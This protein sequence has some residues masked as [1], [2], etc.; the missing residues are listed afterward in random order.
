MGG[1]SGGKV[2]VSEYSMSMHVGICA[3]GDT[4]ELLNIKVGEKIAWKGSL[5]NNDVLLIDRPELF[6]GNKKEGGLR[7]LLWWLPGDRSQTLPTPLCQRLGR[8][9]T[10]TPGFRG[11]ASVFFTGV[12]GNTM[13]AADVVRWPRFYGV[14]GSQAVPQPGSIWELIYTKLGGA[15]QGF[16]WCAN[17][18]YLKELSARVRRAPEGLNPS[19]AMI[20]IQNASDGTAQYAANPAH[21]IFECMVNRDWGMGE[22]YGAIDI[23]SYEACAQTL[24]DEKFGLNLLWTRQAKIEDFIREV[25]DHVQGAQFVDPGTGKHTMKL[26]RADYNFNALPIVTVDNAK[27]GNFKRKTWGEITNE[28]TVTWTNP[29]SGKEETVTVQDNAAI[30]MQGSTSTDSRN[31]HAIANRALAIRVAERDLAA[32]VHPI[33]TCE[34]EVSREFWQTVVYGVV[35]L[36]WEKYGIADVAFRV[37]NITP[38]SDSNTIKLTIHEDIFARARAEYVADVDTGWQDE[39]TEPAPI[40]RYKLGTAPAFLMAASL[41]LSDPGDI[42]YPD[43]MTL[44]AVAPNTLNDS[45]YVLNTYGN[46]VNG[47]RRRI[48]L[49]ERDMATYWSSTV[50]LPE[51]AVT[52]IRGLDG[53]IGALPEDE[54]FLLIGSGTDAETEIA[55]I[56]SY[57]PALGYRVKRGVLDTTPKTWPIGTPVFIFPPL[58]TGADVT[59]RAAGETVDYRFQ[60]ITSRGTLALANAPLMTVALTNRAH[61][62]LR[63]AN[64]RVGGVA[65]GTFNMGAAA[66]VTVS[67]SNRNR[68]TEASQVWGWADATVAPEAG[69]TTVIRVENENG[70]LISEV[71][72]LA[73]TS[74]SLPRSAFGNASTAF[75]AVLS[76]RNGMRSLQAHRVRVTLT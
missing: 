60:T 54:S 33:A 5:R 42:E 53:I 71:T 43:A 11:L 68:V 75:V 13:E 25:L 45:G 30:A 74:Y 17:N 50:A 22:S 7:G 19:I 35:R 34:V 1:K 51:Q 24:Y 12:I 15:V 67:W 36:T 65:F 72:D 10:T 8:T 6:G 41:D 57:S 63:P 55:L 2:K 32:V 29:E 20:K 70:G 69:Q 16:Y 40:T 31:Y 61:R 23:G 46:D 18:P 59:L 66:N 27:L 39:S 26:L 52:T 38:G 58:S 49:G 73:G 64:V 62:P 56:E 37:A 9:R 3:A 48:N 4:L 21:I 14:S 28:I 47:I 44:V 76:A